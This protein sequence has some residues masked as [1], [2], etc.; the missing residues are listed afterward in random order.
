LCSVNHQRLY[1][2]PSLREVKM[3]MQR[4]RAATLAAVP[5][6]G[7]APA[8]PDLAAEGEALMQQ[9]RDWSDQAASGNMEAVMAGWADD[10]VMMAPDLPPLE[11]KAAIRQHV[12]AAMQ[13]TGVTIRWEPRNVH[14]ASSGDVA[15]MIEQNVTTANDSAGNVITTHGKVVT[16]WRKDETGAWKNVVDM[17]NTAPPPTP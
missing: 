4:M 3:N 11:G 13:V 12:E 2:F 5:L 8:T 15:Y 1:G 14:V 7:C 16:V 6:V 9:S 10:A 17:W